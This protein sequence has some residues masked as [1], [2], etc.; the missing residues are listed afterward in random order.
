MNRLRRGAGVLL[1]VVLAAG[2]GGPAAVVRDQEATGTTPPKSSVRRKRPEPQLGPGLSRR[3]RRAVGR[4]FK[5]RC[6]DFLDMFEVGLS[7]GTWGRLEVQYVIGTWGV[8]ATGGQRWR[9]GQRSCVLEEDTVTLAPL[10]FPVGAALYALALPLK[11]WAV[12]FFGGSHEEEFAVWPDPLVMGIPQ[13]LDRLRVACLET[14]GQGGLRVGGDSF[15]VGAEVHFL[16]GA[17]ARVMPVQVLDFVVGL[18]GWDLLQDDAG[19]GG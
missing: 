16:L 2:C 10:P 18:L 12:P 6:L 11:P 4:Y 8:G 7:A 17:R 9:L 13:T 5:G 15:M 14:D 1:F 19:P 3:M